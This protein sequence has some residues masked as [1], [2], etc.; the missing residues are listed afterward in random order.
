MSEIIGHGSKIGIGTQTDI[1]GLTAVDFG[2]N[3]VETLDTTNMRTTGT[4]RTYIGGLEDPGDISAKF[5]VLPGDATQ[6]ALY[7]L[8]DGAAK[9]VTVT[10]PGGVRVITFNAIITSVDESIPDDKIP[11][12]SVK[13]K[14]SGAK[15]FATSG[16]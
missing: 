10:Y 12:L 7:T 15:T 2:S 1:L 11:T 16:S 13:L 3:K 6:A 9:P 4:S 8:K 14:I 5:N